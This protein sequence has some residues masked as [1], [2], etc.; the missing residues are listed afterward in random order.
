MVTSCVFWDHQQVPIEKRHNWST[1]IAGATEPS[2]WVV[3]Y[4]LHLA[5]SNVAY[6]LEVCFY[7]VDDPD[8][9]SSHNALHRT[10]QAIQ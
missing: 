6:T 3:Q 2:E 10:S 7:E 8:T 5:D 1:A 9:N 4:I